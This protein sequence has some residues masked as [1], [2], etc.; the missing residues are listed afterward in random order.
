MV[1]STFLG[2]FKVSFRPASW[3]WNI[4]CYPFPFSTLVTFVEYSEIVDMVEVLK[5]K[6]YNHES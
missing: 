2:T 3:H 6:V 4:K 1:S 5:G